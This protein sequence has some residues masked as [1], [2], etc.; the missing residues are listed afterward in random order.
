ML[1]R[2]TYSLNQGMTLAKVLS[3]GRVR[4]TRSSVVYCTSQLIPPHYFCDV[5]RGRLN[6]S[7]LSGPVRETG[8]DVF[9]M[10]LV[11]GSDWRDNN[12]LRCS[13]SEDEEQRNEHT[14]SLGTGKY[15]FHLVCNIH[16]VRVG[17]R[18][19]PDKVGRGYVIG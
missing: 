19:A 18:L 4:Y 8:E 14:F 1:R 17:N 3:E 5:V 16:P 15:L 10:E 12:M 2:C 9:R 6:L 13:F 11:K 7:L